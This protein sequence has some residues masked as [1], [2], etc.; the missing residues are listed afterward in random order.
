[1]LVNGCGGNSEEVREVI[2]LQLFVDKVREYEREMP[3][4][5][6]MKAAIEY[7]IGHDILRE[8]LE[9]NSSE[10]YNML[11]TEWDTEEVKEV[12]F[13]EGRL[14][15][16]EKGIKKGREGGIERE[17]EATIKKMLNFGIE[18]TQITNMLELPLVAVE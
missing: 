2:R 8:F 14:E 15:G 1:M 7:C 5:E 13:E 4:E 3:Q 18:M 11:I 12:W 9:K 16:I 10:V 6:A 17:R